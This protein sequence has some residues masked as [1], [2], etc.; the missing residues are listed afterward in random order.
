[1]PQPVIVF[2]RFKYGKQNFL[3]STVK[4]NEILNFT[5]NV[6]GSICAYVMQNDIYIWLMDIIAVEEVISHTC[7]TWKSA[8]SSFIY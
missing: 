4:Q 7:I 8:F 2:S 6:N 1:M 5:L 3:M